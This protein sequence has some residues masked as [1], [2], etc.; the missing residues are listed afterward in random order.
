[1]KLSQ[2][3]YSTRLY[4]ILRMSLIGGN[5]DTDAFFLLDFSSILWSRYSETHSIS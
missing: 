4:S 5:L 3:S 1:M 2:L